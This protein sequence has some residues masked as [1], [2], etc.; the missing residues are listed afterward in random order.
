MRLYSTLGLV[1]VLAVTVAACATPGARSSQVAASPS[2]VAE[3]PSAWPL[4]DLPTIG[5]PADNGAR[6]IKVETLSDRMRD[7]TIESPS[8]GTVQVR[9]LL[10]ASHGDNPADRFAALYLLHG[11]DGE[12]SDWTEK[13]DVEGTTAGTNLLVVMPAG[14]SSFVGEQNL[15]GS[16]LN[17]RPEWEPFHVT[18]LTQLMERNWQAS[19]VRALAGLSLGGYATIVLAAHNPGWYR[20][21]A[22]YSGALDIRGAIDKYLSDADP[23]TLAQVEA[24][25]AGADEIGRYDITELAPLL[26][27]TGSIYISYGNGMPGPLDPPDRRFRSPLEVWCGGG[28]DLFVRELRKAGV[29]VTADDYGDGTHSWEYW[30]HELQVSLPMFLEALGEPV[31]SASPSPAS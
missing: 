20:A 2:S 25:L 29:P 31:P 4:S 6:I 24:I 9:L 19:D 16:G 12:Y 15:H 27:G 7:L 22:S 21:A 5:T 13:S 23:E 10:P 3:S 14:A 17:G 18:E 28:S 26:K 1:A 30:N 11:A 8:V